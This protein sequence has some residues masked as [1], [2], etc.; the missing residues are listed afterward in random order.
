MPDA[1]PPPPPRCLPA[2]DAIY[3]QAAAPERR[4]CALPATP[5]VDVYAPLRRFAP[6]Q[7]R[8][9]LPLMPLQCLCSCYGPHA[10]EMPIPNR[11][12]TSTVCACVCVRAF[13][14]PPL[15]PTPALSP[16]PLMRYHA[17][18]RSSSVQH[19]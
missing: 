7:C 15:T 2:A 13:I 9:E 12:T 19:F 5:P 14:R 10:I 4:R 6:P 8:Y 1:A 11:S 17:A 18:G 16:L 3:A